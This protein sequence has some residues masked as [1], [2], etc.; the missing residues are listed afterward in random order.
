MPSTRVTAIVVVH[1]SSP[2]R[3]LQCFTSLA[4]SQGVEVDLVVVDNASADGGQAIREALGS[5]DATVVRLDRNGGF[6]AGVNTGL[7]RTTT[8]LVWIMNDDA[9]VAPDSIAR[10]V[11]ALRRSGPDTVAIAP[12]VHVAGLTSPEGHPVIDT[13]GLV[14][15]PNAEAFSAG[16][17]QPDLGQY[18]SGEA[19]LGPCFVAGLFRA[20]AFLPHKVGLLDE[21][22]FL[23]YE[24]V[25]WAARARRGGWRVERLGDSGVTH[26]HAGSTRALGEARRYRI[27]QRNLLVFAVLDLSPRRA[28]AVWANRL[29]VHTKGVVTGPYR[30][31]RLLAVLGALRRLPGAI[32]GHRDRRRMFREPDDVLFVDADDEVPFLE[33]GTFRVSDP[34]AAERAALARLSSRSRP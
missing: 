19:C 24:D 15:R 8:E 5:L 33:A 25:D 32:S 20:D 23:Y 14:V 18:R 4:G 31:E 7:A 28:C 34:A 2:V 21:R 30:R 16:L 22:F 13:A 10:C 1:A 27:V 29:L 17:G 6:A 11:R 3:L 12:I 9:A 26:V